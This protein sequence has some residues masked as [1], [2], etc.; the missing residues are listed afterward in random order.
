MPNRIVVLTFFVLMTLNSRVYSQKVLPDS[1]SNK[2]A[3]EKAVFLN[4]QALKQTKLD[5]SLYYT[6]KAIT[7]AQKS[8]NDSLL[9]VSN[10]NLSFYPVIYGKYNLAIKNISGLDRL[11]QQK[12]NN[13]FMFRKATL[14]AYAYKMKDQLNTSLEHYKTAINYAKQY[15]DSLFIGDAYNNIGDA[16]LQMEL[17]KKPINTLS[18]PMLFIAN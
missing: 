16:Y 17:R 15:G 1:L 2:S 8:G 11:L 5:S 10:Y 6:R 18:T 7:Y 13:Y 14:L 4:A 3:I 9:F 12:Q